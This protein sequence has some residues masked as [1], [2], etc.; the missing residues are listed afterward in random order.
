M[1]FRSWLCLIVALIMVLFPLAACDS[2]EEDSI[3]SG[4]ETQ[5]SDLAGKKVGVMTG[6]IQA[7][8]IWN[9][10]LPQT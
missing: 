2:Q 6:S 3:G 10:T 9:S 8:S 7:V 1:K 4:G 5:I